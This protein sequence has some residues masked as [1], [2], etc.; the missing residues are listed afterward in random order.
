MRVADGSIASVWI[1]VLIIIFV[2]MLVYMS[3]YSLIA[4]TLYG[5]VVYYG[6]QVETANNIVVFFRFFPVPFL[7][8]LIVWGIISSFKRER[9][10]YRMG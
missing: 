3:F 9:D 5:L 2:T 6:G 7:F 8:S 1:T 10:V 4:V